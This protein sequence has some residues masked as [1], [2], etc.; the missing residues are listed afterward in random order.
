MSQM[1]REQDQLRD[2]LMTLPWP[3]GAQVSYV[4]NV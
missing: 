3:Q 1:A 2:M 4:R